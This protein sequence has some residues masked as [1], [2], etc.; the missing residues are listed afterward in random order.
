VLRGIRGKL[1]VARRIGFKIRSNG[2]FCLLANK[3]MAQDFDT[4]LDLYRKNILEYKVTG[5][6]TYKIAADNAQK[7][8]DDYIHTIRDATE[9]NNRYVDGF[10]KEYANTNPEL[11]Q[12]QKQIRA[13]REEGPKLQDALETEQ[14]GEKELPVDMHSYYI[15]AGVVGTVLAIVAV[16]SL[17][18]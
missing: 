3:I 11:T 7:W 18:P 12:M 8:M 15:K 13:A 1:D 10:V 5:N 9:H 4:F 2:H 14:L 6:S 17:F 16:V